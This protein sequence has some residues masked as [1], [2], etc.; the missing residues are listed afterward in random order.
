MITEAYPLQWPNGWPRTKSPERSRF[1]TWNSKPTV[2]EATRSVIEEVRLLGG[3]SMIISSNMKLRKDGLPYSSQKDPDDTG[4]A[5]YFLWDG[6]QKVIACDKYDKTGC[7]LW[8]IAKTVNAMR[9]ID[10][11]GCTEVLNRAF[12]G[13]AALPEST[14]SES[15]LWF[16]VLG[17]PISA[18]ED[19]VK[20]A[21][22][23]KVMEFHPDSTTGGNEKKFM[24]VQEAY[25]HWES[26]I[27]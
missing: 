21:Y 19:E 23:K 18:T 17:V 16:E 15:K 2:H 10:R 5:V 3:K 1:G 4:M 13:F 24:D 6:Q 25:K 22:R 12:A 8:A 20:K 7:N 9:G 11:W 14:N 27:K 26:L